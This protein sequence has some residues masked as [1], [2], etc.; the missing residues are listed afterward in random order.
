MGCGLADCMIAATASHHQL[1]LATLNDK[2][3]GM[4]QDVVVPYQKG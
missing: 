2:H 4:L 3:F 1:E